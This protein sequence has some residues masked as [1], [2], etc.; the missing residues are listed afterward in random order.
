[1]SSL[2][3]RWIVP[4]IALI[5][6]TITMLYCLSSFNGMQMLFRD[7]DTGWHIRNGEQ[8]LATGQVPH[9][10]PYSF[11]KPAQPWFAWEWLADCLMAMAHDW[12]GMRGV[13]FLYLTVIG[14]VSWLWF[15]LLWATN[16][17]F[18][19]GAVSTWIMLTTCNIHWLA[20]P[21]LISWVFLLWAALTAER[22]PEKLSARNLS[23]VFLVGILWANIHG[24]FFLGSAIFLLYGAEKWLKSNPGWKPL[25]GYGVA[26]LLASFVNPYGW[27]VHEHILK[28]LADKEL[29]SRI[30]EFQTFNFHVEGAE[31][32]V[33]GM[34]VVA[35]GISLNFVQ[36]NF[37]RAILCIVL[38]T[39]ALRSARGLPMMVLVA[40]PL[41]LS[42]ICRVLETL[43]QLKGVFQYNLN[44][45]QMESSFK[46]YALMPVILALF[47]FI[48]QSPLFSKP[49]GFPEQNFPVKLA[50]Q[51]EALPADARLFSSD[52]FG[53]YM[54]YRFAGKRKVFFDGRSDYYGSD[55]LQ[56][57][58]VLP[59]AKPGWEEQWKRWNFTH[60]LI[61]K[62]NS[63]AVVLPLKGWRQIGKDET[64]ILFEKGPQ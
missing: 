29:L 48:G 41:A 27:H 28:Y 10:E 30:G 25:A 46:G 64:A 1:M 15:Q 34:L 61:P 57:Y 60:A 51:I 19:L 18:L 31:A 55:F 13:F 42:A 47:I 8:V 5:L 21:H 35:A 2:L 22:A 62:E 26:T 50:P 17:W 7:S 37:A 43:P 63:L 11:S 45:R 9:T 12:D 33:L 59:D 23:I 49:A 3:R 32:L 56:N 38:F 40:L 36:G 53:G 16:T 24:S 58:L 44:L 54:I 14:I 4:D 6:S 39:G 52:K 20:R